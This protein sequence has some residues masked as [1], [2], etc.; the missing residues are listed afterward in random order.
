MN[1]TILHK[2]SVPE[3]EE[4]ME[5][6]KEGREGRGEGGM[7]G[8]EGGWEGRNRREGENHNFIISHKI[9]TLP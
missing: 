6:G 8:S 1:F 7:E 2:L 4:G 9:I 5:G 3:G